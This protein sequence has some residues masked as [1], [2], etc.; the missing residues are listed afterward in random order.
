MSSGYQI[1]EPD[2]LAPLIANSAYDEFLIAT[3]YWI[4]DQLNHLP[5]T[6]SSKLHFEVIRVQYVSKYPAIGVKY[7]SDDPTD[8]EDQILN[9]IK[10]IIMIRPLQNS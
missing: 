3:L 6:T 9:R 7:L 5:I 4:V 8:A 10:G 1:I 2:E